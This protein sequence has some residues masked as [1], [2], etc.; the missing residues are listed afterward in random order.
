MVVG[1]NVADPA[2]LVIA[3][4]HL[5]AFLQSSS[6]QLTYPG[7]FALSALE[8]GS[9]VAVSPSIALTLIPELIPIQT[10]DSIPSVLPELPSLGSIPS[11]QCRINIRQ[12][13][14]RT[15]PLSTRHRFGIQERTRDHMGKHRRCRRK[16]FWFLQQRIQTRRC[17]WRRF[18]RTRRLS[19]FE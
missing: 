11:I 9:V 3:A 18:C 4:Q 6:S 16:R 1:R 14:R 12:Y 7:L 5:Q 8:P 15:R 10:S 13:V 2:L 17:C 19:C